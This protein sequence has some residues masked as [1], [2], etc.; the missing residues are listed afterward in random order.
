V[1]YAVVPDDRDRV[2]LVRRIDDDSREPPGGRVEV[3][4]TSSVTVI[5]ELAEESGVA[6]TL[7]GVSGIYSDPSHIVVHHEEGALQQH[8]V[9]VHAIPEPPHQEP[10]PDHEETVD[11]AWFVPAATLALPMHLDVRRRLDHALHHPSHPWID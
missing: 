3:G 10:R 8:A 1:V 2:L 4:D 11:A 5:R 7:T 9:C 6:I